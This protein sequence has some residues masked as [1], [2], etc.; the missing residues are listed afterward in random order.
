MPSNIRFESTRAHLPASASVADVW[1]E[2][3]KVATS[4]AE[5]S[6]F[7]AE[8]SLEEGDLKR[9]ARMASL[10]KRYN[11]IAAHARRRG[12]TAGPRTPIDWSLFAD[13]E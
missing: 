4:N 3:E 7:E 9:A 10:E 13:E 5:A 6:A 2:I 11:I 12:A 1:W 8:W